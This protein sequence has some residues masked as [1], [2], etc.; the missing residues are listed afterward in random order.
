MKS[1][2]LALALLA[3]GSVFAAP[4]VFVGAGAGYPAPPPPVVAYVAPCPGPGYGWVAGS[5]YTVG[6]RRLWRAGYWAP[7]PYVHA[8]RVAPRVHYVRGFGRR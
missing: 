6:P 3:G 2:L 7:Q 4:A 1:K 8:I 5:W